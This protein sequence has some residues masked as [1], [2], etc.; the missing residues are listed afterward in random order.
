MVQN[1]KYTDIDLVF[2]VNIA[3]NYLR[4]CSIVSV[5]TKI[6]IANFDA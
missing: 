4:D 2:E 6:T 1:N 5:V 3:N